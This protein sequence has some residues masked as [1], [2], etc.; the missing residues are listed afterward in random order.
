MWKDYW[1]G[2][3][4]FN[5]ASVRTIMTAVFAAAMLLSLLHSLAYNLWR[6]EIDRI[7]LE[8][9]DW[10]GR[11]TGKLTEQEITAIRNFANV[12]R[13][14]V[15]EKLSGKT[16]KSVDIY[17]RHK[18]R[19]FRDMPLIAEE[20]KISEDAVSYHL[21]LLSRYLIHD[22][23]DSSPPLLMSF[24]LL[25]LI[26][27][28][29]SLI[30]IIRNSFEL[31]MQARIRQFGILSSIGAAPGQIMACLL[32][33]AVFVSVLPLF[34]GS[35]TG[36][37]VSYGALQAVNLYFRDISGR[38]EAVYGYHPLVFAVT[39]LS[40]GA[41]IFFSA[42]LPAVK[43]ARMTPLE[44]VRNVGRIS[45]GRRKHSPLL[46]MMFGIEGELAGNALRSRR[47][48]MR[49][50]SWSL[51]LSFLGFSLMLCFVTLSDISTRYT[52]FYRY[53]SAWDIM[54]SVKDTPIEE[55]YPA[56]GLRELNGVRDI[57]VYQKA[58]EMC[59]IPE[60]EQSEE[61]LSSGGLRALDQDISVDE[62]GSFRV[63]AP[64]VILD[65][66]SFLRYCARTG[67]VPD[68]GGVLVYNQIW[69][70]LH[71]NFRERK[72]LPFVKEARETSTLYG[73]EG[74][75]QTRKLPVLAYVRELPL[76]REEYE[77]YALVHVIS[78]SM[79]REVKESLQEAEPDS[80]IRILSD[81]SKSLTELN[82][83]EQRLLQHVGQEFELQ[84]ENRVREKLDN[85]RMIRG[86]KAVMGGFCLLL[87][88]IG[89]ADVF[90]N[91]LGFLRQRKRE[92][93]MYM[94][95]G[96]VPASMRKIF[97]IEALII[98]G[99]PIFISL[100]LTAGFVQFAARASN[101]RP[102]IVWREVPAV[103]ILLFAA[104]LAGFT[105]FA[106]YLG[107]KRLLRCDL[108][109]ALRD[110]VLV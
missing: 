78:V 68:L 7:I 14:A 44:A 20:L 47:K 87:G 105:A 97:C 89:I 72:Y 66:E 101:L 104:A 48:S 46:A 96:L 6:Y 45:I 5:R 27:V 30:L 100:L 28:S 26:L 36:I 38:M 53:Q 76:L 107:G 42:L 57:V 91:T 3:L 75:G 82:M 32:Q 63:K 83:L 99:R 70:S 35:V 9:G 85:D 69:D 108:N 52:Y 10:Q 43:L 29:V 64:V 95:V 31:S 62:D 67:N 15:N 93:A 1:K 12:E 8:E 60:N 102:E 25:V 71:S 65:D 103:P 2:Y 74:E 98:A 41:V 106:Y 11:I 34:L 23:Q 79:W 40:S 24:Y 54:A 13:V 33:E 86:A 59:L 61:L 92:F 19:I 22:P 73:T 50:A 77:D 18:R 109:E 16:E 56:D 17:F 81:G 37:A 94:S 4:R 49:L 55:F 51:L 90:S 58:E 21:T 110:N 84:S 88:I 39:V 80:Y